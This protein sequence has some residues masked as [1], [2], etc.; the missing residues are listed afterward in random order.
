[1][2]TPTY[3]PLANLTLGSAAATVTFS[4]INQGYR[5]LI[6]VCSGTS[7]NTSINSIQLRF[8]SDAGSNYAVV[9]MIGISSGPAA[10]STTSSGASGGLT[11]SNSVNVNIT[12]IVDYSATDKHKSTLS[13]ENAMG[14]SYIRIAGSRWANT[15]AITAILCRIDTGANFNT[16]STFALYG[17]VA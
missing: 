9:N 12:Q 15:A 3:I 11:V 8:N 16:G 13:R 10:A 4:S 6:L 7:A 1:M 5:D 2:P 14:D 17:I